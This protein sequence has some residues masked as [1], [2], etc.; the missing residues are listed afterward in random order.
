M[1]IFYRWGWS[2][3]FGLFVFPSGSCQGICR[4]YTDDI[5]SY[6]ILFWDRFFFFVVLLEV[7]C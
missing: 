4:D 2:I 3:N 6:P 1:T 5:L 7:G